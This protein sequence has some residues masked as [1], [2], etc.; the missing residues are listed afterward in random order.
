[1]RPGNEVG[2]ATIV[3]TVLFTSAAD[4]LNPP[5]PAAAGGWES[6]S[7]GFGLHHTEIVPSCRLA[8]QHLEIR[9]RWWILEHL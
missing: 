3:G 5:G 4:V 6:L 1:M 2:S 8:V 7:S 9:T